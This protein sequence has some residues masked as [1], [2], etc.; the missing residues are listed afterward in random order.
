MPDPNLTRPHKTRSVQMQRLNSHPT[1]G[2]SAYDSGGS[3]TPTE[4]IMPLVH[5][6]IEEG[7]DLTSANIHFTG[8]GMLRVVAPEAAETEIAQVVRAT[9]RSGE[10]MVNSKG[11]PGIIHARATILA[12][13]L[14]PLL[15]TPTQ[16]GRESAHRW[17]SNDSARRS[18]ISSHSCKRSVNSRRS[19]LVRRRSCCLV[20][21][22]STRCCFS[23]VSR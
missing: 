10:H 5:T 12:K 3:G 2:G 17:V 19:A 18:M 8:T 20:S 9:T 16:Q 6:G 22:I 1:D 23:L 14:S 21:N 7:H 15:N 4:V 11:V 13:S